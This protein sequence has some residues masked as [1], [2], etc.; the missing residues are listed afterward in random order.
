MKP[1]SL[2][3][4][5]LLTLVFAVSACGPKPNTDLCGAYRMI[6]GEL[7]IL[8]PSAEKG[9]IRLYNTGNGFSRRLYP[10]AGTASAPG[11]ARYQCGDGWAVKAP[12]VMFAE[13][14]TAAG[15]APTL[16]L[17]TT[18]KAPVRGTRLAISSEALE[19]ESQGL[20]LA[21]QL[22]LP[23][24]PGPHPAIV[25]HQG[26]ERDSWK[27][28][29]TF[30]YLFAAHGVA[31]FCYDKRGV[32]S[33]QGK[34][35]M[36]FHTLAADMGAAVERLK[37]HRA[38]DPTR[39]GVGGFSQGGWI[40]P[41]AASE[42]ADIRFVH[43]GFGL[44]D[45]PFDEDREET[46]IALRE[47][48]FS[49]ADLDRARR[50]IAAV[51]EVIRRD[52]KGGWQ[53]LDAVKAEFRDEPFMKHLEGGVAG[54]FVKYPGWALRL[55]A[56]RKM[57]PE[58][59][60]DYDPR[61]TL[62]KVEVPMLWLIGGEDQEAPPQQTRERLDAFRMAGKPFDVVVLAGADHGG[63]VFRMENGH[64]VVT[65]FHPD[66]LRTEAEWVARVAGVG[67]RS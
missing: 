25:L 26:S 32:G 48:G 14:S 62:E 34:L 67:S 11:S 49:G 54:D 9:T 60:W 46:L 15:A 40:G 37:R 50:V 43:V 29:N 10:V 18:G 16:A 61:P 7:L 63:V 5:T 38:I 44:A 24:G 33:S 58:L 31:A 55:L 3:T 1:R 42:R 47:S 41:L 12:A 21:G 22:Y 35:T 66:Y 28:A 45:S 13:L 57:P 64:R 2:V 8:G 36:N 65:G 30:G 39:I 4:C 17:E 52:L 23:E 6:S 51:H 20:R 27:D 59:S 53:Q 19:F 56:R